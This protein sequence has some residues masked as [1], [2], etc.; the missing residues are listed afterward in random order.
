MITGWK[1]D[2]PSPS[3]LTHAFSVVKLPNLYSRSKSLQV[4][5]L[6]ATPCFLFRATFKSVSW[7]EVAISKI[8]Y[9]VDTDSPRHARYS[10]KY[11]RSVRFFV[12]NWSGKGHGHNLSYP[13]STAVGGSQLLIVTYRLL[14]LLP[15]TSVI[16]LKHPLSTVAMPS[17]RHCHL[18]LLLWSWFRAQ[19]TSLL[20]HEAL[21]DPSK[22]ES[23]EFSLKHPGTLSSCYLI[24][25][26]FIFI[27]FSHPEPYVPRR[28]RFHPYSSLDALYIRDL[29]ILKECML[30]KQSFKLVIIN[31]LNSSKSSQ[32]NN[33]IHYF[34][35]TFIFFWAYLKS[36]NTE[37]TFYLSAWY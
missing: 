3:S 35:S 21:L 17:F 36:S 18:P 25:Q 34:Q 22:L 12:R 20:L 16:Q 33:N 4:C 5:V 32:S 10:C 37:A 28:A 29:Y 14:S 8:I 2:L 27:C 23:L 19:F 31:S 26:L 15:T 24:L 30:I 9:S 11:W 6:G 1:N 13:C 7:H